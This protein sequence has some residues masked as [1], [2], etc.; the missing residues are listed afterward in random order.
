MPRPRGT[1]ATLEN[2]A[3]DLA[4]TLPGAAGWVLVTLSRQ[5]NYRKQSMTVGDLMNALPYKERAI[6]QALAFLVSEGH[7]VA[8]GGAHVVRG[9]CAP[10]A[11]D[12]RTN[13][14]AEQGKNTV[15]AQESAKANPAIEVHK[16]RN[17]EGIQKE[18]QLTPLTPQGGEA[19]NGT[20]PGVQ[21]RQPVVV[22]GNSLSPDGET[23]DAADTDLPLTAEVQTTRPARGETNATST[24]KIPAARRRAAPLPD[25]PEDLAAV[26]GLPEAW[27]AWLQYRRER[28]LATAPSTVT[29]M[30]NKLRQLA[31]EGHP[32]TEVIHTSITNGWQGLFPLR[33]AHVVKFTPRPQTTDQANKHAAQ[34]AQDIYAA[35]QEDTRAIF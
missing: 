17:K 21:D 3:L 13:V 14:R 32:P 31:A 7:A 2:W 10:L 12:A 30:F 20:A 34:R 25:L 9:A 29:G 11:L 24:A 16:G 8:H 6:Q 33:A 26:P 22:L 1:Y 4:P 28:R 19:R 35:L 15:P 27:A 5:S 18:E 23:A